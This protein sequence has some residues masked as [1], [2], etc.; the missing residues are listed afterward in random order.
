MCGLA[1]SELL[2][3]LLSFSYLKFGKLDKQVIDDGRGFQVV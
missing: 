3:L 2:L 1:N